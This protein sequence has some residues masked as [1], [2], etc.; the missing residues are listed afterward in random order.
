MASIL[1]SPNKFNGATSLN[2]ETTGDP[3]EDIQ[4]RKCR[5]MDSDFHHKKRSVKNLRRR[6]SSRLR[7][8]V[9]ILESGESEFVFSQGSEIEER[10]SSWRRRKRKPYTKWME[11]TPDGREWIRGIELLKLEDG[12]YQCAECLV[13][14]NRRMYFSAHVKYRHLG[15]KRPFRERRKGQ[16]LQKTKAKNSSSLFSPKKRM[17]NARQEG[18]R[19]RREREARMKQRHHTGLSLKSR[20]LSIEVDAT[21]CKPGNN[22][23]SVQASHKIRVHDTRKTK[24][25][26]CELCC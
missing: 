7:R 19:R 20:K 16:K 24:M 1:A 12:Q 9:K 8:P 5:K 26:K 21:N 25:A 6:N 17:R 10:N 4:L 11:F 2:Y 22:G 13:V 3:V 18:Q 14:L 23:D 15:L